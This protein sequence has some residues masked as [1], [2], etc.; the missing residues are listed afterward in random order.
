[1]GEKGIGSARGKVA[2]F[3]RMVRTGSTEKMASVDDET[4][5]QNLT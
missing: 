2:I 5:S 1:M 3:N 4:V